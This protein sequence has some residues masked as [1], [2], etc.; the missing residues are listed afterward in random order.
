[1]SITDVAFV[2]TWAI[3]LMLAI[4]LHELAARR[5]QA[6]LVELVNLLATFIGEQ[7]K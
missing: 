3:M 1:M 2:G 6:E 7:K 4:G 5:R